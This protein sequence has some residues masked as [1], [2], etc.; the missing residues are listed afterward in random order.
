MAT[1]LET[2]NG[3]I[4]QKRGRMGALL[5][6]KNARDTKAFTNEEREEFQKLNRELDPLTREQEAEQ[7]VEK[8]E[9]ETEAYLAKQKP[10]GET[11]PFATTEL[12]LKNDK[13]EWLSE[14]EIASQISHLAK[15]ETNRIITGGGLDTVLD[16]NNKAAI[17]ADDFIKSDAFTKYDRSKRES[18]SVELGT[19]A[20]LDTTGFPVASVRSDIIVQQ[21][22]RR[23]VI[24]NLLPN[25]TITQPRFLYVEETSAVNNAAAVAQGGTKPESA[26]AFAERSADVRK[27]ATVLP[28]TDEL[29]EDAPAMRSYVQGR[30][31]V[32]LQLAEENQILNGSGVA[33]NLLG[34]LNNTLIQSHARGADKYADA[35]YKACTKV[36]VVSQLSVSAIVLH[37]YDW[38]EIRLSKDDNGQYLFGSPLAGDIER[39]FGYPVVKTTAIAQGTALPGAWDLAAMLL[40]KSGITFAV[41]TEHADFF[42]KNQLMLRVEE[43]VALPVFRPEGFIEV[44]FTS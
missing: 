39:V 21:P 18:P 16:V 2:L 34:I 27:I 36:Q 32:F 6:A 1:R 8:A 41:S 26:L 29:F 40:R 14:A 10:V 11:L 4:D 3:E 30:M 44:D 42:I 31:V 38:Q 5:A 25:G 13:G 23:L 43:R 12:K 19:K 20:L 35:L 15:K 17:L 33:P 37:P 24:A 22:L 28:V 7:T 9:K